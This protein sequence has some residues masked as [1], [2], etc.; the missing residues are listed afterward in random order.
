M[1]E[2]FH[3]KQ[4]YIDQARRTREL[5]GSSGAYR[6]RTKLPKGRNYGYGS[7]GAMKRRMPRGPI[8][9]GGKADYLYGI[10]EEK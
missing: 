4:W 9:R 6:S 7:A 10:E 2:P 3:D 5:R 1:S 8:A